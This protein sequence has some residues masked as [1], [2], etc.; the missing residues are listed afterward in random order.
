MKMESALTPQHR[1]RWVKSHC[2]Q[3]F[4]A[5]GIVVEVSNGSPLRIRGRPR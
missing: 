1:E 2:Q 3:C 4:N 5:C